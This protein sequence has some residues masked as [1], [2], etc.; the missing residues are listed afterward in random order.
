LSR[1]Q[2]E[3]M[4]RR[5]GIFYGDVVKAAVMEALLHEHIKRLGR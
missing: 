1:Y 3:I 5:L 2:E 4:I